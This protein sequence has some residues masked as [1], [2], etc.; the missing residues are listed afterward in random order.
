MLIW[1]LKQVKKF[2]LKFPTNRSFCWGKQNYYM[3]YIQYCFFFFTSGRGV[4][5]VLM[6]LLLLNKLSRMLIWYT[7]HSVSNIHR[8]FGNCEWV[9]PIC[10]ELFPICIHTHLTHNWWWKHKL[11][12]K[13][14][15]QKIKGTVICGPL[16]FKQMGYFSLG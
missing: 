11:N 2:I 13:I 14:R 10:P 3:N 8:H 6:S 16:F 12:V 15:N 5:D 4:D 1:Y 9:S 7:F